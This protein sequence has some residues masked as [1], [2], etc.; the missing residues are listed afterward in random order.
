MKKVFDII[1]VVFEGI[2]HQRFTICVFA[3]DCDMAEKLV[4]SRYLETAYP[5]FYIEHIIEHSSALQVPLSKEGGDH[6]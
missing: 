1:V 5:A 2:T 6:D 3:N 4:I